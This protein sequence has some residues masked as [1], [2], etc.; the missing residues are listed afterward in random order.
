MSTRPPAPQKRPKNSRPTRR[1]SKT[2]RFKRPAV[3]VVRTPHGVQARPWVQR[4][5]R[6]RPPTIYCGPRT[7]RIL[8]TLPDGAVQAFAVVVSCAGM[9][10]LGFCWSGPEKASAVLVD[11][12]FKARAESTLRG[13]LRALALAGLI[14]RGK[15]TGPREGGGLRSISIRFLLAERE[16]HFE[17]F[18]DIVTSW[19]LDYRSAP[20]IEQSTGC[21]LLPG[22][23]AGPGRRTALRAFRPLPEEQEVHRGFPLIAAR[24]V[25]AGVG[26]L[27]AINQS[28][29]TSPVPTFRVEAVQV[30]AATAEDIERMERS[31]LFPKTNPPKA[32]VLSCAE[33][34]GV[35]PT[36]KKEHPPEG[37]SSSSRSPCDWM[38]SKPL[39]RG[40]RKNPALMRHL[41]ASM[42]TGLWW[43]PGAL[44]LRNDMRKIARAV[45]D[46]PLGG[47]G[48]ARIMRAHDDLL[49]LQGRKGLP[50]EWRRAILAHAILGKNPA[51]RVLAELGHQVRKGVRL[52]MAE[53]QASAHVKLRDAMRTGGLEAAIEMHLDAR[54]K[55][56]KRGEIRITEPNRGPVDMAEVVGELWA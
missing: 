6:T 12:G 54:P 31:G 21:C 16:E 53:G 8:E 49:R 38:E 40:Q 34:G 27:A 1:P 29:R 28:P 48:A 42:P 26:I 33:G 44:N 4:G 17:P 20:T 25:R 14:L 30:S 3:E 37:G 2:A 51:G 39:G 50:E 13:D 18:S 22:E 47:G 5:T 52:A 7:A 24:S 32:G 11:M 46:K 43:S 56:R 41:A 35:K 45:G 19:F 55:P 23:S 36:N 10:S 9:H 15:S